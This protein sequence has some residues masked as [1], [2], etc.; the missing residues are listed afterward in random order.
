MTDWVTLEPPLLHA[1]TAESTQ[2]WKAGV[3]LKLSTGETLIVGD[4][5]LQ[6]GTCNCCDWLLIGDE[7]IVAYRDL[8]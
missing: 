8:T 4:L 7:S 3:Q 2:W 1:Y 6:R 5:N